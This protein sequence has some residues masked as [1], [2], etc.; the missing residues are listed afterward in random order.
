MTP[1]E[2]FKEIMEED[3]VGSW[4][5]KGCDIFNGLKIISRYIPDAFLIVAAEHDIIYSV[6]V[7]ELLDAGIKETDITQLSELNWHV[8]EFDSLAHYV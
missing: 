6:E 3:T 1:I 2:R 7:Q 8:S 4:D 5:R